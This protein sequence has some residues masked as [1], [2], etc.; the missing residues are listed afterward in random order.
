MTT[1]VPDSFLGGSP[2]PPPPRA[3]AIPLA[4]K[5]PIS[6]ITV[7]NGFCLL[8]RL[9]L[10]KLSSFWVLFTRGDRRCPTL[11]CLGSLRLG[12][13]P[14]SLSVTGKAKARLHRVALFS[15]FLLKLVFK[16]IVEYLKDLV[17]R[18]EAPQHFFFSI[19]LF[20][21]IVSDTTFCQSHFDIESAQRSMSRL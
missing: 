4:G 16:G 11:T 5:Y 17:A 18:I 10:F 3:F 8:L 13:Q 1:V 2:H 19:S 15:P 20:N 7:R 6:W 14:L 12:F 21:Q 9:H